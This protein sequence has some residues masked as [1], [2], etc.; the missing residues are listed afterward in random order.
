MASSGI[1]R[2][3]T[4]RYVPSSRTLVTLMRCQVPPK[5]R[6]LQE[7]HDINFPE[8]VTLHSYCRENLKSYGGGHVYDRSGVLERVRVRLS[9]RLTVSQSVCLGVEPRLGLMTR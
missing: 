3:V 4:C 1:L 9:L 5:R 7:P 8:D 6:V 2:R